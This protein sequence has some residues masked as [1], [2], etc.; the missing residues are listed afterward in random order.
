M[1]NITRF[2]NL[3]Q[4]VKI[5]QPDFDQLAQ[6]H[7]AVNYKVEASF[8]LQILQDSD[9]L[10]NIA[11]SNQDSFKRAIINVA[12]IGLTLSPILKLAYLIP[13]KG[14]VCLDISYLGY[15]QLAIEVGAIKWAV[16]EIVYKKDVFKMRGLGVEPL[17]EYEAFDDRGEIVGAYC[18]AKTHDGEFLTT[19]MTIK[20]I[21]SIRDRSESWNSGKSSPWKSDEEEMIK[22]TVVRRAYKSWPKSDTRNDRFERAIDVTNEADPIDFTAIEDAKPVDDQRTKDF[23]LIRGHLVTLNRTEEKYIEHLCLVNNREIKALTDLTD[24]EISQA[25]IMLNQ[26]VENKLKKDAANEVAG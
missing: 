20:Q 25:M 22:K 14:K 7:K 23:E 6:I 24:L 13:R 5:V 15:I 11:M 18:V 17:H 19:R 8:A 9:Y 12:A 26:L 3:K 10:A 21:Y 16:A 1:S 2:E 4:I